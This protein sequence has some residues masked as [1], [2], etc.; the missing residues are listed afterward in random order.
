[1]KKQK[2]EFQ[3]ALKSLRRELLREDMSPVG[4][5][6]LFPSL[7]LSFPDDHLLKS[8][9]LRPASWCTLMIPALERL[10]ILSLRPDWAV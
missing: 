2:A 9:S 4:V 3:R 5:T 6:K 7:D 8:R 10:R 1:M